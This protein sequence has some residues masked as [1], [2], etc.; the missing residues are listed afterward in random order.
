MELNERETLVRVEQQLKD[1]V[2]N[3]GQIMDDLKEI[4]G[5]IE[6]DSKMLVTLGSDVKSHMD[7]TKFRWDDLEKKLHELSDKIR[8]CEEEIS[9]NTKDIMSYEDLVEKVKG[10]EEDIKDNKKALIDEKEAR[11]LFQQDVNST[12]KTIGWIFGGLATVATIISGLVLIFQIFGKMK[13]IR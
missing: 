13:G 12:V 8:K 7:N 3:Q 4:F 9:K 6:S 2:Q 5:R 11:G 1:S 10:C